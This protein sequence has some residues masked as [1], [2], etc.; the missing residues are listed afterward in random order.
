M[1]RTLPPCWLHAVSWTLFSSEISSFFSSDFLFWA[2]CYGWFDFGQMQNTNDYRSQR[3]ETRGGGKIRGAVLPLVSVIRLWLF[4]VYLFVS[5]IRCNQNSSYSSE[6]NSLAF[7][8]MNVKVK[9]HA[10]YSCCA[11]SLWCL[12]R[13]KKIHFKNSNRN[14]YPVNQDSPQTL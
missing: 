1:W 7:Q 14:H 8:E 4:I 10:E 9:Q 2:Q 13:Q 3:G 11:L 12:K 5:P 6:V